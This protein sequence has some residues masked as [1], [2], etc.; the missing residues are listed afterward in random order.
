MGETNGT[1][2]FCVEAVPVEFGTMKIAAV[3][4]LAG[5]LLV[6]VGGCL[7][8]LRKSG[9]VK[10]QLTTTSAMGSPDAAK[11]FP[12]SARMPQP[13]AGL[14]SPRQFECQTAMPPAMCPQ[15]CASHGSFP[16][17]CYSSG[18]SSHFGSEASMFA[19]M[20]R[21]SHSSPRQFGSQASMAPGMGPGSSPGS[22]RQLAS[23]ASMAPEMGPKPGSCYGSLRQYASQASMAPEMCVKPGSWCGSPR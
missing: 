19:E 7:W 20:P 21:A 14:G 11:M 23:Q 8:Y 17:P 18:S 3:C 6:A 1:D 10:E 4:V 16:K 15:P 12:Q 9:G 22:S 2:A 5:S 13:C